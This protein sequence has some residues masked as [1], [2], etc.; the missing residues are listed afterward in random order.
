MRGP[1]PVL[2]PLPLD[3]PFDY[4][5]PDGLEL[6]PGDFV[7]VPFGPRHVIGVVWD[8]GRSGC[9]RGVQLKSIKRRLDAP[10][11][12]LSVRELTRFVA[13]STLHPLGAALKLALPVPAALEPQAP[14]LGLLPA[15][16]VGEK[17][18]LTA[19][20]GRVLA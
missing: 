20:R 2:L 16:D 3:T 9:A 13:D 12:P 11:M 5:V 18:R 10:S 4:A 14:R 15:A 8:E 17:P 7:E 1:V 19:A 6:A